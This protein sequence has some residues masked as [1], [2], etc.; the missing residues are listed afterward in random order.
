MNGYEKEIK[1]MCLKCFLGLHKIKFSS[2]LQ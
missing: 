1:K 2:I